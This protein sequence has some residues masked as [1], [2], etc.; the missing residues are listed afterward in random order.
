MLCKLKI[1]NKD[2]TF[3]DYMNSIGVIHIVKRSKK[4]SFI[5]IR[6]ILII[7]ILV[8][9]IEMLKYEHYLDWF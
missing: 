5:S 1:G 2:Y 4:Y 9:L 3:T 8:N 7:K 6:I